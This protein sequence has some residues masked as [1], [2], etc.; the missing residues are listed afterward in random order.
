MRSLTSHRAAPTGRPVSSCPGMRAARG[1]APARV[2]TVGLGQAWRSL[3][4]RPAYLAAAVLTLASGGGSRRPSSRS[5]T[6][7]SSSRCP[8]RTGRL[9]TVYESS[10]SARERTSLI[11]PGRVEDW[12]RLNQTFVALSG[13]YSENVTDTSGT[14]PE[15]LDGRRVAP[16]FFA[17]YAMPP[18]AGR[19]FTDEEE[20]A[21]GPG[22]AMI[23]ERFWTRRFERDPAA[24]GRAL[25]IGGRSYE[26]VGVMPGAFTREFASA[27]TDVWLPAQSRLHAAAP[28]RSLHQ[29]HRP[30]PRGR[31]GRGRRTRPGRRPGA[32]AREFPKTD[33]GWSAKS[34]AQGRTH[35]QVAHA[36]SCSSS[37]PSSL[38]LIA[39]ANIAGLTLVQVH[40]RARELAIRAALGASR[41]APSPRSS[42]KGSSS[43]P[44]GALGEAWPP[45]WSSPCRRFSPRLRASTS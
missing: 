12:H 25:V 16:R 33:A 7:S 45:G 28:R 1:A 35:R 26:I 3:R 37:A 21:N 15:R 19:W 29:R 38:W 22:A 11:A 32:L 41:A 44:G 30:A 24:V 13:S 39:V 18:L 14:E 27:A 10:P 40:R 9:V 5:S 23:S 20:Q 43:P 17:V 4:R 8:I 42:A 36:G 31:Q 34:L 6:R 2:E